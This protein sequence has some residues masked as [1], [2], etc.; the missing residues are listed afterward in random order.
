MLET[1]FPQIVQMQNGDL[2]RMPIED[3]A[4]EMER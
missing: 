1:N 3:A 2:G 4:L